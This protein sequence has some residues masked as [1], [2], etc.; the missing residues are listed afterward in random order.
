MNEY[1]N[2]VVEYFFLVVEYQN[3]V[4]EYFFLVVEYQNLVNEYFFL[5]IPILYEVAPNK[6]CRDVACNVSTALTFAAFYLRITNYGLKI[7]LISS[8]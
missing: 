6:K 2:L 5:V 3:L 8:Q 7:M 4:N 1:Q